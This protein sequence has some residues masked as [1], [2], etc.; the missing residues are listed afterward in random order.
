MLTSPVTRTAYAVGP[1]A[2]RRD[3][4]PRSPVIVAAGDAPILI[5][6]PVAPTRTS[7]SA[8]PSVAV[9]ATDAAASEA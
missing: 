8:A 9:I 6:A 4:N 7:L 2:G 5:V 1:P 3:T